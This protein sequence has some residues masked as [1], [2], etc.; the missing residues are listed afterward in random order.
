ML[1]SNLIV[2][3]FYLRSQSGK[4]G[5]LRYCTDSCSA[6]NSSNVGVI[7]GQFSAIVQVLG[8]AASNTPMPDAATD[9]FH[10]SSLPIAFPTFCMESLVL[11]YR[12]VF[13][14]VNEL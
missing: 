14:Q 13:D 12:E 6:A 1:S 8:G 3:R 4:G 7:A 2:A 5:V 10:F 9:A 11:C